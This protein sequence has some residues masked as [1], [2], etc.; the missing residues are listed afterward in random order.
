[1]ATTLFLMPDTWDLALDVNGNIA[2]ATSTYQR[3]QDIASACRVFRG[4]I[5]FNQNDGIPYKEEI[6]GKNKYPLGLYQ[7][8][9][10]KA[11]MSVDGVVTANIKLNTLQNR[12]LTGSIEF[13]D[14]ENNTASIQL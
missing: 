10:H 11:A 9:L 12:V 7:S 5:Y 1:M 4:D 14:I 6:L 3:A 2:T 8:E 13:T